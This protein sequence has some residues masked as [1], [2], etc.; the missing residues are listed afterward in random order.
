MDLK[1]N[2]AKAFPDAVEVKISDRSSSLID[3]LDD[4][5][6][7]AN[8]KA[9]ADY[10]SE[11]WTQFTTAKTEALK[12]PEGTNTEIRAKIN[13]I[14]A[15]IGK[16]VF[17]GK[18]ALDEAKIVVNS[19]EQTDYT[20]ESWSIFVDERITALALPEKTNQEI[21]D[22]TKAIN[23]A[24]AKLVTHKE[25][26]E[27]AISKA[28]DDGT[29]TIT[30]TGNVT[31]DVITEKLVSLNLGTYT[32]KGNVSIS[33]NNAGSIII[34]NGTIDGD[35]TVNTPN[36]TVNN[37]ATV[38]GIVT[39]NGVKSGTWNENVNGNTIVVNATAPVSLNIGAEHTVGSLTL[40][41]PTTLTIPAGSGATSPININ[42]QTTIISS[43]PVEA[44]IADGITVTVKQT[45]SGESKEII[46]TGGGEPITI[47]TNPSIVE[48]KEQLL[49]AIN[50]GKLGTITLAKDITLD[51]PLAINRAVTIDGGGK[52]LTID[53][54]VGNLGNDTSEGLG[55]FAHGV[56]VKNITVKGNH[57]D[58]LI[59]IYNNTSD[60]NLNLKVTL[61]NVAAIGGKKSGIYVNKD[62]VGTITVDFKNITT[63]GNGWDAGIGLAAQKEGSKVIAK[64]SGT[65]NFA[66]SVAVYHEGTTYPGIYEVIDLAGYVE[67]TIGEQVKWFNEEV[68]T[69]SFEQPTQVPEWYSTARAGDALLPE[70]T[71]GLTAMLGSS[72]TPITLKKGEWYYAAVKTVKNIADD[73]SGLQITISYA[74]ATA[75]PTGP[76]PEDIFMTKMCDLNSSGEGQPKTWYNN[77]PIWGSNFTASDEYNNGLIT[78]VFIKAQNIGEGSVTMQFKQG[79]K[80]VSNVLVGKIKVVQ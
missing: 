65:H 49:S 39:I 4:V 61:E 64:F 6:S 47:E 33:S 22:K 46:G 79:D 24:I 25:A 16:L 29:A 77:T 58:N 50:N 62:E 27:S 8:A 7:A 26:L 40:N 67:A 34:S 52:T 35:L 66:E 72:E 74:D 48:T 20:S 43:Q 63:S 75:A 21:I 41:T 2:V 3:D 38:T 13:A 78:Y 31:A 54:G 19:K 55:I 59:E 15:A 53:S 68:L 30:L 71:T 17:A 1:G 45:D 57:G 51:A 11:S 9:Q 23:D 12:L 32:I 60:V 14:N 44:T 28:A 69:M 10:T 5:K 36:A 80:V 56:V 76:V 73:I 37:S 42:A 18:A 70:D